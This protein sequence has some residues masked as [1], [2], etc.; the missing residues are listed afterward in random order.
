MILYSDLD[1]VLVSPIRSKPDDAGMVPI[2]PRPGAKRFL[3][4]LSQHGDVVLI[5]HGTRPHVA[6]GIEMLGDGARYLR[7][8]IT[9]EDMEP[10]QAQIDVVEKSGL[11]D[12]TKVDLYQE[13]PPIFEPGFVFDD[14]PVGSW[15]YALKG[16][17]TATP[18]ERWIQVEAFVYPKPDRGGL[19]KAYVE[20]TKRLQ[21]WN[22]SLS[23]T[24]IRRKGA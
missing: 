20:F 2:V 3:A 5:S 21:A 22:A 13:I 10:I 16:I 23:G 1:E 14:F 17:A 6:R 19:R 4:D 9:R 11:P 15:M 7:G 12:E 24:K 8:V 18:P